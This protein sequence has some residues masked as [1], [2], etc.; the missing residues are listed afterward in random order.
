MQ[1]RVKGITGKSI[2]LELDQVVEFDIDA[3]VDID[4]KPHRAKRSLNANAYFHVLVDKLRT[5]LRIGFSECKN[6]VITS[7]GQV[8]YIGDEQVIIKT[9]IPPDKMRQSEILHCLCVKTGEEMG[10]NVYFYRVYRGSH[11]YD[12]REMAQLIDGIC[13]E[14]KA[15]GIETLTPD[16]LMRLDGYAKHVNE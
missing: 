10:K 9:N 2:L 6:D 11:T 13:E 15:Q 7:Y 8:E 16:E 1:G 5:A 3:E 4:I 14:C 12:S